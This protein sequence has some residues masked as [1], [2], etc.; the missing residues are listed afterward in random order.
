MQRTHDVAENESFALVFP[1]TASRQ[2]RLVV[3]VDTLAATK[4]AV[5]EQ[6]IHAH[7]ASPE[8]KLVSQSV[9][10]V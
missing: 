7:V 3:G 4:L 1:P 2:V 6:K 8:Q 9:G 10:R 5:P